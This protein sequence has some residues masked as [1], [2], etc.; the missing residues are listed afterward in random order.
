MDYDTSPVPWKRLLDMLNASSMANIA[1]GVFL[2]YHV[3][4]LASQSFTQA[5]L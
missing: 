4:F 3:A 1:V 5:T 2:L